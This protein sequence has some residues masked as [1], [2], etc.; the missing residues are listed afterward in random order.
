M[1]FTDY[2]FP[3]RKGKSGT[4]LAGHYRFALDGIQGDA[5]FVAAMF[6]LQRPKAI[7]ITGWG[8]DM[9]SAFPKKAN[10]QLRK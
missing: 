9:F 1:P 2:H 5:D 8:L 7:V 6:N 4:R 10:Y 3:E